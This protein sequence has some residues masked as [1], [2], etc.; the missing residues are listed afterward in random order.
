MTT[1]EERTLYNYYDV[2]ELY[3]N[4]ENF[5]N[6]D[7]ELITVIKYYKEGDAWYSRNV[8]EMDRMD[9]QEKLGFLVD[10]KNAVESMGVMAD[11]RL[12]LQSKD[13]QINLDPFIDFTNKHSAKQCVIMLQ[14]I[15]GMMVT[16]LHDGN[17]L[18]FKDGIDSLTRAECVFHQIEVFG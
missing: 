2:A 3:M 17:I 16:Y 7:V 18:A 11:A 5:D 14:L 10:L 1:K 8:K 12:I 4:E 9:F 15:Q 6:L 13:V